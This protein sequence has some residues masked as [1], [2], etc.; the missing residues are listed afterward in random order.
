[1]PKDEIKFDELDVKFF[2]ELPLIVDLFSS[3]FNSVGKVIKTLQQDCLKYIEAEIANKKDWIISKESG[4]VKFTPFTTS[5]NDSRLSIEEIEPFFGV[6]SRIKLIKGEE[7]KPINLFWV[8]I[9][10]EYYPDFRKKPYLFFQIIKE[11]PSLKNGGINFPVEFYEKYDAFIEQKVYHYHP[12][13]ISDD[14]DHEIIWVEQDTF[15][16]KL[17]SETFDFFKEKILEPYFKNLN[18]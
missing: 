5:T 13:N 18:W 1:M 6:K 17:I 12:S 10:F 9:A 7:R 15:D 14:T 3:S 11:N 2:E 4:T 16:Y 8:D